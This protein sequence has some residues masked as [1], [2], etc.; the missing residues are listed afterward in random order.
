MKQLFLSLLFLC[1]SYS[2]FAQSSYDITGNIVNN[3]NNIIEIGDVLLLTQKDKKIAKY[4][5]VNTGKF[6]LTNVPKNQY[7]LK[8]S[9]L[10]YK[11]YTVPLIL[12]KN[13]DLNIILIEAETQLNEINIKV[14]KKP[15]ENNKGNFKINVAN[16]IFS[17]ESNPIDLL[18]K[19]PNIQIS[20]DKSSISIIG[21][22]NP[23]IYLENQRIS[24][25]ELNSI[26]IDAIKN[27]D[28]INNPSAKYEAEG[29]AVILI[30]KKK[31]LDNGYKITIS[32]TAS[33]KTYFNNYLNSNLSFKSQKWEIKLNVAYNQLK[34]WESHNATYKIT[35][36]NVQSKYNVKAVT[37][38]P[39]FIFGGGIFH[40]FNT[41]DYISINTKITKQK[42]PYTIDTNSN[43]TMNNI[44]ENVI[45]FSDNDENRL[46]TSTSINYNKFL[47]N[48]SN[49][50]IGTQYTTYNQ[51]LYFNIY[52]SFNENP[53]ELSQ[54]RFQDFS[55]KSFSF[56]VDF[57]KEIHGNLKVELGSNFSTSS[58]NSFLKKDT[59]TLISNTTKKYNYSEKNN[60]LYTQLSG[61]FKKI[62]YSFGMR[63]EKTNIEGVFKKDNNLIIDKENT[64]FFPKGHLNYT[65]NDTKSIR[66]NYNKSITRPNYSNL[67]SATTFINP[68]L[69]FSNNI[70]TKPTLTDE[71]S[72]GFQF[73]NKSIT[74]RYYHIKNPLHY[75]LAYNETTEVTTMSAFNFEK[76]SGI[77]I[78][79]VIPLKH[80]LW[81]ST[82]T[83]NFTLN[84]I[85][86]S[87]STN[88]KATPFIYYYSNNQFKITNSSSIVFTAWGLTNRKEGIFNRKAIF[89]LNTSITKSFND[90]FNATLSFNDL[91]NSMEFKEGYSLQRIKANNV[92]FTDAN[93]IALSLK[94]SFGK[95]K[96]SKYKNKNIDDNLNRIR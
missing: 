16:T 4:T 29:R 40:Q 31:N 87:R 75:S 57:E 25:D 70:Y 46:L 14:T 88:I 92:F 23:L 64:F 9:C 42:D 50:F 62:D 8:I 59:N 45:S 73:K 3:Q 37:T 35:H 49:L 67:N 77:S 22:G 38:R 76:E 53:F 41:T 39:Q 54:K 20:P 33:L 60:A 82:N 36:K 71:F 48:A 74:A 83:L 95:I 55:I 12:N 15:I 89:V 2:L 51:N 65:I 43:Y 21:K 78:D 93:E 85:N 32:E 84:T 27:I 66:L 5:S 19:L 86:D 10:G 56:K 68:Y 24:L 90:N 34:V 91:F 94:Y 17:S 52:N 18:S 79:F 13:I 96:N 30:T 81:N 44:T 72:L 1:L 28:I 80:K 61:K 11:D 69:E 26:S 7:V 58:S 63:V 47:K 6:L